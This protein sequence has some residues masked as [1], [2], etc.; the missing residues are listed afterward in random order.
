M[1]GY[2]VLPI[3][4]FTISA[5]ETRAYRGAYRQAFTLVYHEIRRLNRI[6]RYGNTPIDPSFQA[7]RLFV[8]RHLKR[9]DSCTIY[10][11]TITPDET[12]NPRRA[13]G[14]HE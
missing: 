14:R 9:S 8:E 1:R 11:P 3:E 13:G 10:Y 2:L 7:L 12:P 6:P 4:G 5:E